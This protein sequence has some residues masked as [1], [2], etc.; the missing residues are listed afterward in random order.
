MADVFAL[1]DINDSVIL[2]LSPFIA[3]P[4]GSE[5]PKFPTAERLSSR[6][7]SFVHSGVVI[8]SVHDSTR[9]IFIPIAV[10]PSI[11]GTTA[12]ADGVEQKW[13][14]IVVALDA[15]KGLK[16]QLNGWAAAIF[17][18]IHP[19]SLAHRDYSTSDQRDLWIVGHI[20]IE[21]Q[22]YPRGGLVSPTFTSGSA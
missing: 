17:Y 14:Q 9:P 11:G 20:D 4:P 19:T 18:D 22:P 12:T 1:T 13:A 8:G 10:R 2:D 21:A 3:G 6:A 15:A 7:E 5:D 16:V